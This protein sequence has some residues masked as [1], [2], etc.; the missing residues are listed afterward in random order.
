MFA[1]GPCPKSGVVCDER[2]SPPD[3]QR[4]TRR[5]GGVPGV[6]VVVALSRSGWMNEMLTIDWL[7]RV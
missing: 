6:G 1:E 3:R 2:S 4:E 7:K 5:S